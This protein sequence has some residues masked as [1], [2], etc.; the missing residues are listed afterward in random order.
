MAL[1][2]SLPGRKSVP[3]RGTVDGK[4]GGGQNM[5]LVPCPCGEEAV[6]YKVAT[7]PE[8]APEHAVCFLMDEVFADNYCDECFVQA[9]PRAEWRDWERL[10]RSP[11]S[12]ETT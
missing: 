1:P 6:W 11:G 5:E 9:V 3:P 10:E 7:H 8:K 12:E 4:R 2:F